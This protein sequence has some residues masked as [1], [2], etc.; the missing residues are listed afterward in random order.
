MILGPRY[1][2]DFGPVQLPGGFFYSPLFRLQYRWL[3]MNAIAEAEVD[4]DPKTT[5]TDRWTG[6]VVYP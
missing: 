2:I 5:V 1:R 4:G 6:E 3:R